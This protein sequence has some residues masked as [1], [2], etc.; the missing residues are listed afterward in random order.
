M[1]FYYQF[2]EGFTWGVAAAS[3][4]IEGATREGGKGESV[5]DRFSQTPGKI[6]D[7]TGTDPACDH[8]HRYE[9][10]I[11][12][13]RSLGVKNYRLS[14]AWPRI[15]PAGTGALNE[16]GLDFYDRLIDSLLAAGI[17]PHVTLYHWD[18]PQVLEDKNGWINRETAFAFGSY[19]EVVVKRLRD[20]VSSWFTL[21]EM[22]CFIGL[23]YE[24]GMHAPGRRESASIVNQAYHH[25]L[26]AHGL[27]VRAV[28]GHGG[29]SARVGLVHNPPT[30]L[31]VEE[32][33]A[34]IAA[35]RAEYQRLNDQLMTPIYR[36]GGYGDLFLEAAGPDAPKVEAGDAEIMHAP[37]DFLGLNLYAGFF[38]RANETSTPQVLAFPGGFPRGDLPWINITPQTL[39]WAVRHAAETYGIAD[40]YIAENGTAAADEVT[41]DGEI[42]DL[43]RREYVRNYLIGLH[44]AVQEGFGVRGYFLWTWMDNFEWAEGYSKRFGIVYNNYETQERT[45][46]LSARWYARVMAENR[47]V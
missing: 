3:A 23:S 24:E 43:D 40:F 11:A 34:D 6:A 41:S 16:A 28:R 5:W 39:Y 8:Y 17:T 13:M 26:L 46:K 1:P 4:Q 14:I 47:I 15:L 44:R 35:S 27:G 2:P 30:P 22:P 37:G 7:G 9:S 10:D 29:P 12:L 33:D 20:R 31:P 18:L 42:L 38:V 21:N 32:T 36:G 25:A 45:P 19:A